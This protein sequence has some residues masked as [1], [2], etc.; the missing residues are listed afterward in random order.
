MRRRHRSAHRAI[1]LILVGLLPAIVLLSLIFRPS[2]PIEAPP[3]Q[4]APPK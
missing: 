3:A 4:L 1:W 2:G